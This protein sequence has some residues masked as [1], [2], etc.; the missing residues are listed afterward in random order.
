MFCQRLHLKNFRN[1]K[2]ESVP[3]NPHFN[4]IF[5][6]N[7]QGKTN[8]IEAIYFLSHLK[9]FRTSTQADLF[10]TRESSA[11]IEGEVGN[12]N[13]NHQIRLE[14]CG[15]Q[16]TVFL[17]EKKPALIAEY[18]GLLPV[19]LFEPW[20]V[21]L[22]REPPAARRRFID[23]ALFL[24]NPFIL[25]LVKKY[26]EVVR[27][28]NRLLKE[29]KELKEKP[30]GVFKEECQ[31]WDEQVASLGGD[32]VYERL[33]W[34]SRLKEHLCAEYRSITSGTEEVTVQYRSASLQDRSGD[35]VVPRDKLK[36]IILS[37]IEEMRFEEQRRRESLVG[38]HRDDWILFI[39]GKAVGSFGSQGENRSAVIAIKSSQVKMFMEKQKRAPLFLMDDVISELDKNRGEIL[40]DTLK[41][42]A[43][44]VFLT[45]TEP[46]KISNTYSENSSAFLIEGGVIRVVG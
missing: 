36:Q 34:M 37:H 7:G 19:V 32:I 30:G 16:R 12:G 3:F 13:I 25:K 33:L 45:T 43:G 20:E 39:D 27:Q 41:K 35:G 9:S 42:S 22:F 15:N 29:L 11:F 1:L 24:E 5:G 14:L 40:L 28:K 18:Y 46:S 17:N 6:K 4:V 31:V 2:N 21:Y 44:Q 38:P 26:A 10:A 23:R 8:L